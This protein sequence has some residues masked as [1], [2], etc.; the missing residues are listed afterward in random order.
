MRRRAVLGHEYRC[1]HCARVVRRASTKAWVKSYC[2][3]T[4]R[5]VHLQRVNTSVDLAQ[6]RLADMG[7]QF[8]ITAP[9]R[10]R[11]A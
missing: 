11:R 7:G 1:P 4:D 9:A 3:T 2:D 6:Q 10:R 5:Y 8:P